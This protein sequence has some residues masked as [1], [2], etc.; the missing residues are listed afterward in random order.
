MAKTK[1]FENY[2]S[3]LRREDKSINGVF[4]VCEVFEDIHFK[5]SI[6]GV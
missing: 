6:E 5:I 2:E 1:I 4:H 3:L